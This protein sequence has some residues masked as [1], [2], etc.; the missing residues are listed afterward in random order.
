MINWND[1]EI[2]QEIA[3]ERYQIIVQA[4]QMKKRD[5]RNDIGFYVSLLNWLGDQLVTW[6]RYLQLRYHVVD[7]GATGELHQKSCSFHIR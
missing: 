3:Q 6:G 7:Q 4:R 5:P 2:A 1:I